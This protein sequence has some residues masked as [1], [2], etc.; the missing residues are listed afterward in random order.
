MTH[1]LQYRSDR[2][3][4]NYPQKKVLCVLKN[5]PQTKKEIIF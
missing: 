3:H 1:H 5:L 2:L 4:L